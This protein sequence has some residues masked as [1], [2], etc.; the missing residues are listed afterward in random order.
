MKKSNKGVDDKVLTASSSNMGSSKS[1]S[2][3][4]MGSDENK[5][6]EIKKQ[7]KKSPLFY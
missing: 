1:F 2:S 4:T 6:K 3:N 7:R 5:T